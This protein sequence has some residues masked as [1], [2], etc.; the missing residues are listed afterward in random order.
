MLQQREVQ[1][2]IEGSAGGSR[3][4][5]QRRGV[6]GCKGRVVFLLVTAAVFFSPSLHRLEQLIDER[7][8]QQRREQLMRILLVVRENDS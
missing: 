1:L 5:R 6:G 7:Q 4:V 8:K 3:E 2:L